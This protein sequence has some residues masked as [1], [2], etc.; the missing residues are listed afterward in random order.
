MLRY[1]SAIIDDLAV[2]PYT[3]VDAEVHGVV[4]VERGE[5][6]L[7]RFEHSYTSFISIHSDLNGEGRLVT[8]SSLAWFPTVE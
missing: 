8:P 5:E 4:K 6:G 7:I 3:H 2:L 1:H